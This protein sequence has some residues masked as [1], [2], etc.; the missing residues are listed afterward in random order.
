MHKQASEFASRLE[1]WWM[2]PNS[3]VVTMVAIF[4]KEDF[5]KMDTARKIQIS[6]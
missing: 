6:S 1:Q 3:T 5:L 2:V 4:L